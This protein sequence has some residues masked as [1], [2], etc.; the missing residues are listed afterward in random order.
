[1]NTDVDL[2][3]SIRWVRDFISKSTHVQFVMDPSECGVSQV[4]ETVSI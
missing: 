4:A 1:M 3:A 2:F